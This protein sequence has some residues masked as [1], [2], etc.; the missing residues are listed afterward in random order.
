DRLQ[1]L[2]EI[3]KLHDRYRHIQEV[4]IQPFDPKPGT[5]MWSWQP[6]D[7]KTLLT[8]VALA[9]STLPDVSVQVPPNLLSLNGSV[10]QPGS[11]EF[12]MAVSRV[13]SA[14]A[15]DFGGISSITPDFINVGRPWPS[16]AQLHAAIESAGCRPRERLPIYPRFINEERFMSSEVKKLVLELADEEGYRAEAV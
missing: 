15:S 8:T 9:R 3:K 4:I 16:L 12:N 2:L 13:I 1:S 10:V 14:G 11:T 5:V 6:P 7:E